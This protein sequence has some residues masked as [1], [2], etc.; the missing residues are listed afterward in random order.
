MLRRPRLVIIGALVALLAFAGLA[1][2]HAERNSFLPGPNAVISGSPEQISLS[3]TEAVL[4]LQATVYDAKGQ[5]VS[6]GEPTVAG[7]EATLALHEEL[8]AGT[9]TVK[10]NALSVDG[11]ESAGRYVYHVTDVKPSAQPHLFWNGKLIEGDVP[12]QIIDGRLMVPVR[13]LAESMGLVASFDK[14]QQFVTVSPAPAMGHGHDA[15]VAPAESPVP[16]LEVIAH[17]DAKT[18][19]VIQV[20]T[21]NWEWAPLN[22]NTA[23]VPNEGHAH[24]YLDGVKLNRIYG[25]WYQVDGVDN[26]YHEFTVTLNANDHKEYAVESEI[27]PLIVQRTV[28]VLGGQMVDGPVTSVPADAGAPDHDHDHDHDH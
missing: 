9:Y 26:G 27:G 7:A 1:G 14:A 23:A 25:E 13:A 28:A 12:T 18:G 17:K 10:W 5:A 6:V 24:L 3:F 11:H 21:T 22:A 8:P 15:Y 19:F 20:K 2:A 16:T 4:A